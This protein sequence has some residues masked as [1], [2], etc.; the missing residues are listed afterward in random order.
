MGERRERREAT[1]GAA[2]AAGLR[3]AWLEGRKA[4]VCRVEN[5]R[6]GRWVVLPPVVV[7]CRR[8]GLYGVVVIGGRGEVVNDAAVVNDDVGEC[9]RRLGRGWERRGSSASVRSTSS[10]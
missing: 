8:D 1:R 5:L 4:G 9:S 2:A 3:K 6:T 10:G 7:L